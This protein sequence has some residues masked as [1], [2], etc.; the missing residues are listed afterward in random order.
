M[1]EEVK[2][3]GDLASFK[4]SIL[5]L[6]IG[7]FI[8]AYIWSYAKGYDSY[9]EIKAFSQDGAAAPLIFLLLF[10]IS[11][12]FPL[13]LLT[14]VGAMLFGFWEVLVYSVIGS[15]LNA[16][17]VFS[18]ARGLGRDFVKRF[19]NKYQ[20]VKNLD[21]QFRKNAFKD[22]ILLR[23]FSILPP[24]I[25]NLSAGLSSME[26]KD[27]FWGSLIGFIPAS[28]AAIFIVKGKLSGDNT[29]FI[30]SI[31]FFITILIIPIFYVPAVRKF[32]NRK[33][34][35]IKNFIGLIK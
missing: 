25:V 5:I 26:F 23:F 24:E 35:E 10:V 27:Y 8:F 34:K 13:P 20:N 2:K 19:E 31:I 21:L 4:F 3:K 32:A 18:I 17:I 9:E 28:L 6:I 15:L 29:L 22:I 14:V 16:I 11:S 12:F 1:Q 33:Y 7:V 30:L